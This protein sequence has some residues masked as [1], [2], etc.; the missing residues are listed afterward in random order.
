MITVHVRKRSDRPNLQLCYVDPVTGNRRTKSA[1]TKNYAEAERAAQTWQQELNSTSGRSK[2]NWEAFRKRFET[3]HMETLAQNTR[4]NYRHGLNKFEKLI[5]KPRDVRLIDSNL[6]SQYAAKLRRYHKSE[7][8]VASNLMILRAVLRWGATVGLTHN[9]VMR[10]SSIK[11]RGRPISLLEFIGFVRRI[12]VGKQGDALGRLVM[13]MWLGGLRIS[14]ALNLHATQP[15]L[16]YDFSGPYPMLCWHEGSQK[17]KRI[18]RTPVTPDFARY[19]SRYPDGPIVNC[20]LA[21]KTI[22]TRIKNAGQGVTSHDLRKTFGT[23]W[24]LRV[25]PFVLKTM[26][27]HKSIETTMEY[28]IDIDRNEIAAQ[29]WGKNVPSNVT[30]TRWKPPNPA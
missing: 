8:T 10:I 18:E 22:S 19:L 3:E 6:I 27:R 13:V 1:G 15:P 7:S 12:R 2:T 25:H 24:A 17:S 16:H 26:M 28:Y 5:G 29:I 4:E 20:T 23:R 21:R 14:E 30:Q 9:P 11:T